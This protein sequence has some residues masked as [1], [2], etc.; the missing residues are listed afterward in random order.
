M[1]I[2]PIL[3]AVGATVL[4]WS[5][6]AQPAGDGADRYLGEL[7]QQCPDRHLEYLAPGQLRDGLDDFISSLPEDSQ[8][9]MR[10]AENTQSPRRPAAPPASTRRTWPSP[11]S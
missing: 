2:V 10:R 6:S 7:A 1:R 11:R 4:A 8:D 3:L 5:A 9:Q